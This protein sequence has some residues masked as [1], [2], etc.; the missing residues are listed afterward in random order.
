MKMLENVKPLTNEYSRKLILAVIGFIF[1]ILADK[2]MTK[3]NSTIIISINPVVLITFSNIFGFM[4]I[5]YPV[6]NV[7]KSPINIHPNVLAIV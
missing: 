7:T 1:V 3:A 4:E 5:T 6:I 2:N